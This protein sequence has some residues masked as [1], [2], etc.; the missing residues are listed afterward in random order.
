MSDF[1]FKAFISYS[2]S[3]EAVVRWLHL[4]LESYRVPAH[5]VEATDG[6]RLAPI[7]RDKDELSTSHSL[8]EVIEEALADSE[9]LIVVCS[10]SAKASE[11]VNEEIRR[12]KTL[13]TPDNIICV[14]ADGENPDTWFP[15]AL[16]ELDASG[17]RVGEVPLA[18][19]IREQ[20]D[21]RSNGK[22][23]VAARLLGVRFDDLRQR[24]MQRRQRRLVAITVGALGGMVLTL[25]LAMYAM[26]AQQE[27]EQMRVVAEEERSRAQAEAQKAK[28]VSDFLIGTFKVSDPSQSRSSSV[29]AKE[30]LDDSSRR[31]DALASEPLLQADLMNTLGEVYLNL[32]LIDDAAP[33]IE[34]AFQQIDEQVPDGDTRMLEGARWLS[35]VRMRQGRYE[36]AEQLM[37]DALAQIDQ[38]EDP[39]GLVR[40]DLLRQLGDVYTDQWRAGEALPYLKNALEILRGQ[41]DPN[42]HQLASV[43]SA[44]GT[45]YIMN[46]EQ[47]L[48][49]PYVEEALAIQVDLLG[50]NH[51]DA[52]INVASLGGIYHSLGDLDESESYYLRAIALLEEVL[53]LAHPELAM[54]L[55]N[56]GLVY[57]DM[58]RFDEAE[59]LHLKALEIREK[60]YG[61]DHTMIARSMANLGVMYRTQGRYE[62][63]LATVVR[64]RAIQ[65]PVLGADHTWVARSYRFEA[66][67]RGALG[68]Q[69]LVVPLMQRA[70]AI[71]ED[72]EINGSLEMAGFLDEYADALLA[73]GRTQ[74]ASPITERA[75]NI[76]SS[77]READCF[78]KAQK[79]C[80]YR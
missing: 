50:E 56:L 57:V 39:G 18:T 33:L 38:V 77:N 78:N 44:I 22:L 31:L 34:R 49:L 23:K 16:F 37:L 52:I 19:D 66:G 30:M 74:E 24:E 35:A 15:D 72:S 65:I 8:G 43:L 12:F 7:F 76:R 2:H 48:A 60:V 62:E 61:R 26:F 29:T 6:A 70:F 68:E 54:T 11:W 45:T 27:A 14:V 64:A 75:E 67:M 1:K 51:P 10:P 9:F 40:V 3:D 41:P 36:E 80:G 58:Q 55:T 73:M 4:A 21:G 28:K 59:A 69:D 17:T 42:A 53:G 46:R 63:A 71:F 79:E 25:G 13:R 20:G 32:G 5:V 47:Q